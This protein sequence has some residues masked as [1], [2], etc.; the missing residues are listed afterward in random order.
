MTPGRVG[1]LRW[2]A[3][4]VAVVIMAAGC[5]T[6]IEVEPAPTAPPIAE[7]TA[8]PVNEPTATVEPT[9]EIDP[10]LAA[11]ADTF[12]MWPVIEALPSGATCT[13]EDA[14][15]IPAEAQSLCQA[16]GGALLGADAV[17]SA[18]ASFEEASGWLVFLV[19][20][21]DG[22]A[23]FNDVAAS[24]FD[25]G[26]ACPTGRLAI[27]FDGRIL[28]APTVQSPSFERDA[29]TISG[30]FDETTAQR[31]ADVLNAAGS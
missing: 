8:A 19:L 13:D 6:T 18:D 20:T 27:E 11:L 17:E 28:S 7:S 26:I 5:S 23:G 25:E 9:P 16:A 30:T 3:A 29:I 22:I 24:C 15:A 10:E 31:L 4:A 12:A 14:T 2:T 1:C 21:N